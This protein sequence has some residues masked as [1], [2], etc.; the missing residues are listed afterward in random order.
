MGYFLNSIYIKNERDFD[1][2]EN[3]Y[4]DSSYKEYEYTNQNLAII[5]LRQ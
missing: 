3:L 2:I 5:F 4:H 1:A